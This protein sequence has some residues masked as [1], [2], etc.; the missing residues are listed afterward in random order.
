MVHLHSHSAFIL[1]ILGTALI[2]TTVAAPLHPVLVMMSR[3]SHPGDEDI[4]PSPCDRAH[5]IAAACTGQDLCQIQSKGLSAG[6]EEND[7]TDSVHLL[8]AFSSFRS[9]PTPI[10]ARAAL[11]THTN[12]AHRSDR[13]PSPASTHSR[14]SAAFV[15]YP[16]DVRTILDSLGPQSKWSPKNVLVQFRQS[17]SWDEDKMNTVGNYRKFLETTMSGKLIID[18]VTEIRKHRT[19]QDNELTRMILKELEEM[20][21]SRQAERLMEE[22]MKDGGYE[23]VKSCAGDMEVLK[24]KGVY[25]KY[26]NSLQSSPPEV[27]KVLETMMMGALRQNPAFINSLRLPQ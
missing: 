2:S 9:L 23:E 17:T 26:E 10:A 1:F 21:P 5:A 20:V 3:E 6:S 19:F 27:G 18:T 25:A 12:S 24:Q 15:S 4:L 14:P 13:E 8:G 16:T 11:E 22:I 7:P